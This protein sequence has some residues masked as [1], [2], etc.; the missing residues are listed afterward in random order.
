M[1]A[2]DLRQRLEC[3]LPTRLRNK[4][5]I[6]FMTYHTLKGKIEVE[7]GINYFSNLENEQTLTYKHPNGKFN[8]NVKDRRWQYPPNHI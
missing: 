1:I 3:L 2:L 5:K 6:I 7:K 8:G 4:L